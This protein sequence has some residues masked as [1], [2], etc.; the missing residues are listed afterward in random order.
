[1]SRNVMTALTAAL[2]AAGGGYKGYGEDQE[3]RTLKRERD[4]ERAENVRRADEGRRL[5]LTQMGFDPAR[6][7]LEN[8]ERVTQ[9]GRTASMA[10][11]MTLP[12]G[13]V[14]NM[15]PV[16]KAL[17]AAGTK[18]TGNISRG[19]NVEFGGEQWVQPYDRTA[20]GRAEIA[21]TQRQE[22]LRRAEQL[23]ADEDLLGQR[24]AYGTLQR[25]G[26]KLGDFTPETVDYASE[27]AQRQGVQL[28]SIVP[29]E[30]IPN[31]EQKVKEMLAELVAEGVS[32]EVPVDPTDP[33]GPRRKV[34]RQMTMQE[35]QEVRF[36]LRK[37]WGLPVT[38][39]EAYE[40]DPVF[41]GYAD[42]KGLAETITGG[43]GRSGAGR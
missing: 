16:G 8:A 28:R 9:G 24:R 38:D 10:T 42:D 14:L 25:M 31:P 22:E 3:R 35:Q 13:A 39:R 15:S 12:G 26:V 7:A 37:A 21:Q 33:T 41:R 17:E 43:G 1:M 6:V 40:F 4:E 5:Q 34:T 32:E 11:P 36:R 29:P 23:K 20:E 27:L 30:R 2:A 18:R 19:R